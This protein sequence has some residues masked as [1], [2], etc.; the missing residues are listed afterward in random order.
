MAKNLS[1]TQ[2]DEIK[3]A[4]I[5]H[6]GEQLVLPENMKIPE[7]I[8][9][10]Q[11]R[12]EYLE[13][14]VVMQEAFD[15]FPWDGAIGLD[16]VLTQMYGWAPAEATPGMWG[17]SPPTL[18]DVQ[19]GVRQNKKV[20]WGRFSL[21]NIE[22]WVACGS[23]IKQGRR[24]FSLMA[25]VTRA[26]EGVVESLFKTLREYLAE[27]SIYRGKAIK[28]RFLD[29]NGSRLDM[30]EPTFMETND[31]TADQLVY[32]RDVQAAVQTNLFTPITRVNDCI[33]NG[34]P[35]KRGVLLGGTFGTGKTLAAKMAAKLAIDAGLTYIYVPRADEL[36]HALNFAMQYQSPAS[37]VFCEDIDRALN[38]ER[39]VAMDDILNIIDGVDSKS[40]RVITVLTTNNLDGIHPAML[41]PGRLDAVIEICA[42]DAEAVQRLLRLYG[43]A[44]IDA[45]TDLSEVGTKLADCI[46]AVIA[47]VVKRAKLSQLSLEKPGSKISKLSADALLEAASTMAMQLKLLYPANN[48][49]KVLTIEDHI[50]KAVKDGFNGTIEAV[51]ETNAK[52]EE[53]HDRIM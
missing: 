46:P 43:G 39:S 7:A 45:K 8:K 19:V 9:L 53:L 15:V 29:D 14:T 26:S 34:I 24:V 4:K 21:P 32:P 37:V 30:P 23:E 18:I 22:G 25:R 41:R 17:S 42:P 13:E 16:H 47:E 40:S 2:A 28:I 33:A 36:A 44:A 6:V 12:A 31:I 5:V 49:P 35:V 3:V 10:L 20:A 27:N 1:A 51:H 11:R 38:G 52:V 48:T 50:M